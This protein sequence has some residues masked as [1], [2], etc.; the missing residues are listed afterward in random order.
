MPTVAVGEQ[1]PERRYLVSAEGMKVFSVL[2]RDPNP[3][4]YDPEFVR[5]LGLGDRPVNQGTITMGY[6]ISAVLEWL[7]DPA[8]LVAFRCRFRRTL[9]AGDVAVAGGEVTSVEA[10]EGRVTAT[11]MIWLD[12]DDGDRIIDGSATV[13]LPT[14]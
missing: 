5:S 7:G 9:L 8:S 2:M 11:L 3:V 14:G 10:I 6:P 13:V 1:L 12:R 4:H